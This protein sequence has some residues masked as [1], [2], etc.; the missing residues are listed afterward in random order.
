MTMT[1]LPYPDLAQSPPGVRAI[2]ESMPRR[3]GVVHIYAHASDSF[4]SWFAFNRAVLYDSSLHP[5]VAELGICVATWHCSPDYEYVYHRMSA[6]DAGLS[7]RQLDA[8]ENGDYGSEAFT[9]AQTAVLR[10]AAEV[11]HDVKASDATLATVRRHL[12]DRQVVELIMCIGQ[13]MLNSRIA[14]NAGVSVADDR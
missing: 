7:P 12:T 1:R 3:L 13:Y 11:V 2:I 10:F 4:E 5:S 8:I 9:P 6:R 14:A